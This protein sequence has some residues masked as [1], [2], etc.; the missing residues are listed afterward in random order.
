[1][2]QARAFIDGY[3]STL[4]DSIT[5]L[6]REELA[7]ALEALERAHRDGRTVFLVGNG[8]SAA[9]ASHMANDMVWG[10]DH[11]GA[12]PFKMIALTDNVPIITAVAN[13]ASYE[14]IF[15][16]QLRPLG[17]AG[18]VLLAI[19]GSGNSPNVLRAAETAR[20]LGMSV[21]S[22]LGKGGGKLRDLSDVSV[23][24]PSDD[25]GPIEV[26]HLMFD[27]L[28]LAYMLRVFKR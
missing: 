11:Y 13:D 25:Y 15:A 10:M 28:A 26:L 18:D 14:S 6:P 5:R 17:S 9:T 24:V 3:L 1:M 23:V 21:I 8:G 20:E 16:V 7:R 4:V 19:S 12:Q 22:F 2:T 27:H